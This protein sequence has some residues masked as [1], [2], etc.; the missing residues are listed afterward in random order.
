[1]LVNFAAWFSCSI[2][3]SP[4]HCNVFSSLQWVDYTIQSWQE[5]LWKNWR[6][7]WSSSSYISRKGWLMI[8]MFWILWQL[9]IPVLVHLV[10]LLCISTSLNLFCF[11]CCYQVGL[12]GFDSMP[13]ALNMLT[14]HER[15][16]YCNHYWENQFKKVCRIDFLALWFEFYLILWHCMIYLIYCFLGSVVCECVFISP[17]RYLLAFLIE[18]YHSCVLLGCWNILFC[19]FM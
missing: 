10:I 16:S 13:S 8:S 6:V 2:S 12:P 3:L 1:M 9:F 14:K 17:S 18:N 5:E 7:N 4:P 19:N 15:A 11:C